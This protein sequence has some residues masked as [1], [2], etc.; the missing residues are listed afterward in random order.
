MCF[1]AP[2]KTMLSIGSAS[3]TFFTTG[4]AEP[5]PITFDFEG[6]VLFFVDLGIRPMAFFAHA[7][8]TKALNLSSAKLQLNG[9]TYSG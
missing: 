6:S 4:H 7:R 2:N 8:P 3:R 5:D 9:S 1:Y